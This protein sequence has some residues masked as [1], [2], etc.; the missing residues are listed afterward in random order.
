[1]TKDDKIRD[2]KLQYDINREATIISALSSVKSDIYEYL[3]GEQVL[4]HD[5]RRVIQRA[6]FTSHRFKKSLEK[7]TE[8]IEDLGKRQ[9]KAI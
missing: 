3:K 7:Q 4:P 5:Q 8:T 9:I 1:M 2:E 6:K